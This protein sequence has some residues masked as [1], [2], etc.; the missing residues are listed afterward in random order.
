M[1]DG[2]CKKCKTV[3]PYRSI[4][5]HLKKCALG[6]PDGK[7]RKMF[8]LRVTGS[9]WIKHWMYVKMDGSATLGDLDG[10]LRDKWLECCGHMSAFE[11]DGNS[12]EQSPADVDP[13][14]GSRKTMDINTRADKVL[15]SGLKFGHMYDFGTTTELSL[16]VRDEYLDDAPASPVELLAENDAPEYR[17]STCKRP[18]RKVCTTCQYDEDDPFFCNRCSKKHDDEELLPVANS[19]R[20]GVCGYTG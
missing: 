11:I 14:P 19:P 18:A 10:F 1:K 4:F 5:S 3:R 12:Y 20:M 8:V 13:L 17:C 15:R 16:T 6:E 9:S 2:I 7:G